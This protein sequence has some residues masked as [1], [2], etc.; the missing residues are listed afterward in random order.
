MAMCRKKLAI[1]AAR[2]YKIGDRDSALL[3]IEVGLH[4]FT[5]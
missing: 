3:V 4:C 5:P 1:N 2:F